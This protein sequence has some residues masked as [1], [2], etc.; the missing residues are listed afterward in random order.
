MVRYEIS[1]PLLEA[2]LVID[3]IT[4]LNL[5]PNCQ[6]SSCIVGKVG[7][8]FW[9]TREIAWKIKKIISGFCCIKRSIATNQQ[10]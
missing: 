6:W 3:G 4:H 10:W 8:G 2:T 9:E 1:A 5:L 7:T